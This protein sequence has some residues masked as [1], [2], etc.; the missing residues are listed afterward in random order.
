MAFG[1]ARKQAGG[2]LSLPGDQIRGAC[3]SLQFV[4][5]TRDARGGVDP[6][7]QSDLGRRAQCPRTVV[8]AGGCTEPPPQQNHVGAAPSLREQEQV[9]VNLKLSTKGRKNILTQT[10]VLGIV[11][12]VLWQ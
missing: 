11:T 4:C 12:G 6:S 2:P 3:A 8:H 1:K 5:G 7:V 9:H 10:P